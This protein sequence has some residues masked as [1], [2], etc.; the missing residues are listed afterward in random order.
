M[1]GN[2]TILSVDRNVK[3]NLVKFADNLPF[4]NFKVPQ[5]QQRFDEK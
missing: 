4:I 3:N 2:K 5:K 1:K